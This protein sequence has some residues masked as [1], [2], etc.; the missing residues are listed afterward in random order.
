LDDRQIAGSGPLQDASG[1]ITGEPTGLA[2]AHVVAHQAAGADEFAP[3]VNGGDAVAG[4]ECDELVGDHLEIRGRAEKK[5]AR[6]TFGHCRER[7]V[8]FI[9]VAAAQNQDGLF[10]RL[11]GCFHGTDL[12]RRHLPTTSTAA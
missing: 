5:A 11:G 1:V 9:L 4:G 2:A 10:D 3:F 7:L 12:R 6:L 8:D